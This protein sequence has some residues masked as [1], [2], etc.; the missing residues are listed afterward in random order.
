MYRQSNLTHLCHLLGKGIALPLVFFPSC[1]EVSKDS[2]P[3]GLRIHHAS[4]T[5]F[6]YVALLT[7][8]LRVLTRAFE[9]TESFVTFGKIRYILLKR[10]EGSTDVFWYIFKNLLCS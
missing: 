9:A 6:P 2:P 7:I 5:E 1:P 4:I 8:L 3:S 10:I